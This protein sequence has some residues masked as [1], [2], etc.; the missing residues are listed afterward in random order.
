MWLCSA[1]Q[2]FIAKPLASQWYLLLF[3]LKL[4][5]VICLEIAFY[6][7]LLLDHLQESLEHVLPNELF[8]FA[9]IVG[10][11]GAVVSRFLLLAHS[12]FISW[13]LKCL[14]FSPVL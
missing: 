1:L 13:W 11:I 12:H 9:G 14:L 7:F 6:H 3:C 4:L 8:T 5:N 10:V 2:H